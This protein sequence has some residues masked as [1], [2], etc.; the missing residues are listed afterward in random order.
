MPRRRG[1]GALVMHM[2]TAQERDF[3]E[4]ALLEPLERKANDGCD[5]ERDELRDDEATDDDQT[6]R[7][8]RR[9]IAGV[10]GPTPRFGETRATIIQ[11]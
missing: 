8:Q 2:A 10:N 11:S 1:I 4:D 6:K 9:A 5:V 3:I 7:A